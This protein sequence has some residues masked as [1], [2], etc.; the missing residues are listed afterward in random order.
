MSGLSLRFLK[1]GLAA[2][3]VVAP[4]AASAEAPGFEL[5]RLWVNPG[6]YSWHF[7]RSSTSGLRD[8]NPGFGLEYRVSRDW[9]VTAGRFTNSNDRISRYA[10][11]Y[12]QP[13]E[14]LG[15]R[16]GVVVGGFDGYP[17]AFD[18]G[19]FPAL[20]PVIGWE[21]S[22]VGLNLALVP[23]YKDRLHGALSFQVKLRLGQ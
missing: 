15:G 17:K 4:L 10:G 2:C 3:F 21:G 8:P 20:I 12:Y 23:S 6:F 1:S 11:L 19:W 5:N 16:A 22:R 14:V 7:D 13:I 9:S 18:G